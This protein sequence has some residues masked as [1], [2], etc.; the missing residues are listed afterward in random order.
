VG[1]LFGGAALEG[2][3]GL[4]LGRL[5]T[6]LWTF[7]LAALSIGFSQLG[8][9]EPGVQ[10]ALGLASV[11]AGGLLGAFLLGL[12]VKRAVQ[13]DVLLAVATSALAMFSLWLGAKGWIS[14]PLARRIAWPW[15]S[16]IGCAIAMG[17]GWISSFLRTARGVPGHSRR[18]S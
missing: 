14:F 17:V 10:V 9:S 16:L 2:R 8:Q 7:V 6:L 13:S 5:L 11:T 12:L 4:W 1:P 15:Y 3:R 18:H